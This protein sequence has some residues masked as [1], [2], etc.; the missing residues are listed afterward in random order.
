MVQAPTVAWVQWEL[1]H[2][3]G[4]AKR[5]K[6]EKKRQRKGESALFL[7]VRHPSLPALWYHSPALLVLRH[8]D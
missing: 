4:A 7:G 3:T 6:E 2:A 5:K 1:P 8:L